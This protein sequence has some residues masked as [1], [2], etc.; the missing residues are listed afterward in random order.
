MQ[1]PLL[2]EKSCLSGGRVV[3]KRSSSQVIER[4][5]QRSLDTD[6]EVLWF[7]A[8]GRGI[9]RRCMGV[10]SASTIPTDFGFHTPCKDCSSVL[11]SISYPEAYWIG[12]LEA[13][14][15]YRVS[16]PSGF[17]HVLIERK[18]LVLIFQHIFQHNRNYQLKE[19][20][21]LIFQHN[22]NY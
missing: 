5:H 10:C 14:I 1:K 17:S 20:L 7:K 12:R 13:R 9:P 11:W 21:V 16:H 15:T 19:S 6:E 3:A 22:S 18:S 2:W 8:R 4:A